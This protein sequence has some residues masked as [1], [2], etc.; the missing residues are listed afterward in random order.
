MIDMHEYNFVVNKMRDFF[1]AKGFI[2]VPVQSRLSILAACEDPDTISKFDFSDI[3]WPLP[4]TGQMWLEYELLN[5]PD[6]SGVFC[7][8]TS[9]RN[10]PDPIPG[11][12]DKIFPMFEFESRGNMHDLIALEKELLFYLGFTSAME[13]ELYSEVAKF[14]QTEILEAE[15][16][17][18]ME[19]DFAPIL[20]LTS[21]PFNSHPFWNMKHRGGDIFDKVDVI[22]HGMETFGGA[23]RSCD[24]NEM[25]RYFY[26]VSDGQ[27]AEKLFAL[28]GRKRVEKELEEYLGFAMTPRYGAGMGV[29][30]MIRALKKEG[31][32][33]KTAKE[34]ISV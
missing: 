31:V 7:I 3:I 23:E 34:I 19:K 22:M 33:K 13:E 24:P 28:F 5:N 6:V 18:K 25:R 30:R 9:Y 21:F 2:E 4:Q 20:F 29:T 16:E 26:S 27:Y 1:L 8:S 15:H 12:H 11:R 17:T 32:L 10:E 14:Y